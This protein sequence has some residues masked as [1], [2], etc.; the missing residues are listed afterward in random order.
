MKSFFRS[1]IPISD[2]IVTEQEQEENE[3]SSSRMQMIFLCVWNLMG[4][5]QKSHEAD[6]KKAAF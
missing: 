3:V 1:A 6:H 5:F 2:Y 4:T